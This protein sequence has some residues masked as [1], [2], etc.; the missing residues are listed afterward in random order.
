MAARAHDGF[1]AVLRKMQPATKHL[2][3]IANFESDVLKL[4]ALVPCRKQG[5]VMM[6]ALRGAATKGSPIC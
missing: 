4:S 1:P 2:V 5:H 6:I 3:Y